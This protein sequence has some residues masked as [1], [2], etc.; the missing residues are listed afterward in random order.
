MI[1]RNPAAIPL[2]FFLLLASPR[3]AA[4]AEDSLTYKFENYTET[5]GRVG[6]QTQGMTANQDIGADILLGLTAVTDA[7]AGATPT[8]LPAPAGSSQV[9][10]AHL[11]D[12]RKAW[13]AGL[14]RAF[15]RIDVATG[16]AESREHDY[17]SK[18][19]SLNTTTDFNEKNT[20]LL[21]GV[22]GHDD[23]VETFYDPERIYVKKHSFNAILGVT[24]ILD[25][26]TTVTLN[27]TWGRETGYLSD[28][29]KVVEQDVEV[30]PGVVFPLV[31][32]ENRPSAHD[33][34]VAFASILV[35][36][37]RSAPSRSPLFRS[38]SMS[39]W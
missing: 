32:S 38:G 17:I 37:A 30:I 31:F 5:G 2:A 34:G 18:G 10:L 27:L 26:R 11:S 1:Q 12:H 33:S 20:T 39:S 24:Q 8:G 7:I 19:W 35:I 28:Q 9:P 16:I 4:R 3:P 15:G 23:D 25:P 6:V 29:Y 21:V 14:S 22:A 13:E 36:A